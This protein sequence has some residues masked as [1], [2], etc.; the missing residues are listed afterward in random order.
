MRSFGLVG[1]SI[2]RLLASFTVILGIIERL[3]ACAAAKWRTGDLNL[4]GLLEDLMPLGCVSFMRLYGIA[5]R[6]LTRI[7]L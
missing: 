3:T 4:S 6:P 1:E 7:E 2:V 5:P